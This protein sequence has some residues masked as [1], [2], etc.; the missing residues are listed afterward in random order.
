[1]S[2]M[3]D[4]VTQNNVDKELGDIVRKTFASVN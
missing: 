1:M 4:M 3:W 2:V